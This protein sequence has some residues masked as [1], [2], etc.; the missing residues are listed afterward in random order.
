[1]HGGASVHDE[2]DLLRGVQS[3]V[4]DDDVWMPDKLKK[5]IEVLEKSALHLGLVSCWSEDE[6]R[7]LSC[8]AKKKCHD[9]KKEIY[10]RNLLG[11]TSSALISK[12]AFWMA[13]GFD[14]SFQPVLPMWDFQLKH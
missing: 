14:T 7:K 2:E 12:K 13:G 11:G 10:F 8:S 4:E 6:D 1:M 5:Q 9:V 3:L